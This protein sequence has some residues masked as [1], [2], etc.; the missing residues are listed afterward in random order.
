[1]VNR[2]WSPVDLSNRSDFETRLNMQE[3]YKSPNTTIHG[4]AM[5][6]LF[7]LTLKSYESNSHE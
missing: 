4:R 3:T 7:E 1:M 6:Q 2:L 5:A